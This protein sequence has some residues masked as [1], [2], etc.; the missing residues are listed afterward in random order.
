MAEKRGHEA[1]EIVKDIMSEIKQVLD[2]KSGDVEKLYEES[3]KDVE[4]K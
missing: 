3:K 1:E 4:Q 2:R